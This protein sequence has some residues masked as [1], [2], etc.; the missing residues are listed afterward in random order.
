MATVK[1]PSGTSSRA[2]GAST[3]NEACLRAAEA[4][5]YLV[6][7]ADVATLVMYLEGVRDPAG[8][9]ALGRRARQ[10]DKPVVVLAA[11]RSSAG[12]RAALSHTAAVAGDDLLLSALCR[13]AG[14]ERVR[15]DDELVDVVQGLRRGAALPHRPRVAVVT[16]SGG[17]GAVL[18]DRLTDVGSQW[19][20]QC[21]AQVADVPA[22]SPTIRAAVTELGAGAV[23][24]QNPIDLS[25]MFGRSID[26]VTALCRL[27]DA[28]ADIDAVVLYFTFGDRLLDAYRTLAD[29]AAGLPTPT[30]LVW[31]AAPP[32]AVEAVGR[33]DVVV[34][35][36]GAAVRQVPALVDRAASV[37]RRIS[38]PRV[39][40]RPVELPDLPG[41]S[42]AVAAG[43]L[44]ALGV[45][46]VPS[47]VGGSADEVAA[48]VDDAGWPG[49]YVI[50]GDAVDVPHRAQHGL[51]RL[52]VS[53][54]D[55][56]DEARQTLDTA[57]KLSVEQPRV[58]IQPQVRHDVELNIGAVRDPVY[59]PVLVVGPGGAGIEARG[60]ERDALLLPAGLMLARPDIAEIDL[61]PVVL[62]TDGRLIAVDSLIIR[63]PEGV[64]DV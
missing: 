4:G 31:A 37:L 63:S 40:A 57:R 30:W 21:G 1:A 58:V 35:S 16:M 11:G 29:T 53:R 43:V 26:R 52:G 50:K 27:L 6:E 20:Q 9:L 42:E 38:P 59:G 64:H 14:L 17:A 22:L 45:S 62:T 25:G 7:Q 41:L 51:I 39:L 60:A 34:P 49:P 19:T 47:V 5:R 2:S 55:L 3:G 12:R 48:L 33:P 54:A 10:L 44:T 28:E 15:D 8:L 36:I 46:Y 56:L 32:G 23:G 61:N 24:D 18:A 13:Q